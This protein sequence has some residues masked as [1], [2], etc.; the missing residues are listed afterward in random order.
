MIVP[1]FGRAR[2]LVLLGRATVH[3]VGTGFPLLRPAVRARGLHVD[4]LGECPGD[5]LRARGQRLK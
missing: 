4:S 3:A 2:A 5:G 1:N